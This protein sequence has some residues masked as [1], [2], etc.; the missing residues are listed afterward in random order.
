LSDRS[1]NVLPLFEIGHDDVD[2]ILF[3]NLYQAF[4]QD[5]LFSLIVLIL[6]VQDGLELLIVDLFPG[7]VEIK[8]LHEL[9]VDLHVL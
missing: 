7:I 2:D 5:A 8:E 3:V 6:N 9:A 4:R 1:K